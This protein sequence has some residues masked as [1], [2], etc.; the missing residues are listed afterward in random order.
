MRL[1]DLR[2]AKGATKARKRVGR[3]PGSGHGKTATKGHKGQGARSGGKKGGGFEGGQMPLYRRLPKRGFTSR[4]RIEYAVVNLKALAGFSANAVVDPDGLVTAG[5]IKKA[6]REA[7]KVLGD[8]EVTHALTVKAH[9]VSGSARAKIEAAG[10]RVELLGA[11]PD[12]GTQAGAGATNPEAGRAAGRT[13]A[14]APAPEAT[15][16]E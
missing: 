15:N 2:P 16:P 3:G 4:N 14:G 6:N 13:G 1:D 9:A 7:V 12:A 5:I 11:A 8:G 10:G